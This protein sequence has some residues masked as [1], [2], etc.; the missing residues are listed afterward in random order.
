MTMGRRKKGKEK[1]QDEDEEEELYSVG[2]CVRDPRNS[3]RLTSIT[4]VITAARVTEGFQW[5][6]SSLDRL[7]GSV[8]QRRFRRQEYQVKVCVARIPVKHAL[9]VA[10][11]G[12]ATL[13][14]TT[15]NFSFYPP[16]NA[17]TQV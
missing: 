5:V 8:V 7:G 15:R 10:A 4:E 1:R 14:L 13:L 6:R 11:S 17:L 2:L 3:C 16:K 12:P 9:I